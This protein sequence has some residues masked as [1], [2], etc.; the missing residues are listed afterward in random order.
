MKWVISTVAAA[1]LGLALVSSAAADDR[2]RVSL[3]SA[4]ALIG[5]QLTL[6]IDV[7]TPRGATLEL[8]PGARS[9]NGIEVVR[10]ASAPPAAGAIA[11]STTRRLAWPPSPSVTSALHP[12]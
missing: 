4:S 1:A 3:S 11:H 2:D 5:Q 6:V 8:D 7:Y 9:W 10:L 12:A